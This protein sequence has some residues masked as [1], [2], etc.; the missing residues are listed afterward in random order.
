MKYKAPVGVTNIHPFSYQ[1]PDGAEMMMVLRSKIIIFP[2]TLHHIINVVRRDLILSFFFLFFARKLLLSLA[3]STTFSYKGLDP[4]LWANE[5]EVLLVYVS[6]LAKSSSC[7]E[8]WKNFTVSLHLS[9]FEPPAKYNHKSMLC[10]KEQSHP[11]LRM[12]MVKLYVLI[13]TVLK[14]TCFSQF[15]GN[16]CYVI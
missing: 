16:F 1:L 3:C 7:C 9:T 11:L 13:L 2:C 15:T 6:K 4:L 12:D 8:V 14:P 10:F 5:E